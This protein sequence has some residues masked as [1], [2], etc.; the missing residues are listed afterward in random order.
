MAFGL[1]KAHGATPDHD[2]DL[3]QVPDAGRGLMR[4]E[5]RCGMCGKKAGFDHIDKAFEEGERTVVFSEEDG[6][7]LP[8]E[9]RREIEV[10]QF[11]QSGQPDPLMFEPSYDLGPDS[12]SAKANLLLRRTLE[13]TVLTAIVEQFRADVTP[14][15]FQEEYKL[16]PRSLI[17]EEK[18]NHR[19]SRETTATFGV[20]GSGAAPKQGTRK[21]AAKKSTGAATS[22]EKSTGKEA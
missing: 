10:P 15:D 11:V 2:V 1:V 19:E 21:T 17:I 18:L 4:Y 9:Q 16:E 12:K 14:I 13:N 20:D 3:H 6:D 8:A 7:M 5:Q 22:K